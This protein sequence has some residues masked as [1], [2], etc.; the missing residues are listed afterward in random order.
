ME[1][2]QVINLHKIVIHDID[3]NDHAYNDDDDNVIQFKLKFKSRL[4]Q[5][6]HTRIGLLWIWVQC[7]FTDWCI[8][9]LW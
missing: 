4:F 1:F 5:L 2:W 7:R 9:F 3:D 6:L 8:Q